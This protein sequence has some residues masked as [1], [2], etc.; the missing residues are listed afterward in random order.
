[1]SRIPVFDLG[2]V[3][4]KVDF[5]PF[6][7]WLS[8][9]SGDPAKAEAFLHSSLFL[10]LEFGAIGRE[11]FA[12]RMSALFRVEMDQK[13]L[14]SR[15]CGIFPGLVEGMEDLLVEVAEKRELYALSNTNEI[16][17]N[18]LNRAY[19]RLMDSFTKVFASHELRQRKP[20]PG[21]YTGVAEA[22][23]V[24]P[25]ELLFFDDLHANV[26]GALSAGL[27]AHVFADTGQV[28][29]LLGC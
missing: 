14:E 23:G 8:K 18:H 1:M 26:Q 16:H 25:G 21:I 10:D 13:E 3:V 27:E 2:N 24:K 5:A 9:V 22:L 7:S 6:V 11:E 28:R 17:L 4:V 15:F 20:F 19:P 12:R 29:L